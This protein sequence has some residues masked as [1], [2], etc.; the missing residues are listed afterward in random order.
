MDQ[1]A[2]NNSC[3]WHGQIIMLGRSCLPWNNNIHFPTTFTSCNVQYF[4][5]WPKYIAYLYFDW[6]ITRG[7]RASKHRLKK[8]SKRRKTFWEIYFS[9]RWKITV[10]WEGLNISLVTKYIGRHSIYSSFHVSKQV[11]LG[12]KTRKWSRYKIYVI[13]AAKELFNSCKHRCQADKFY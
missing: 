9:V 4:F 11:K 12:R 3:N 1:E 6:R 7:T 2:K 10:R 8:K 13:E 5:N